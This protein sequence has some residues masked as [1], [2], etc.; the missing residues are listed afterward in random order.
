[1]P[2]VSDIRKRSVLR[3][4][5]ILLTAVVVVGLAYDAY[6][7]ADLAPTYDA[8]KSSTLSQGDLFRAEAA[9][10]ALAALAILVRPRRYSALFA[11]MV[12]AGGLA[13]VLAYRYID[14]GAIGPLPSMYEPIW[15]AEK[16]RSAFA[17]G[18][19][20]LAAAALLAVLHV[21][22]RG[23]RAAVHRVGQQR[24]WPRRPHADAMAEQE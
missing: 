1:M 19:A 22:R 18:A 11:F 5:R 17:E 2:T 15:Y 9:G 3:G 23:G 10:A 20:A 16:T 12:A 13:A 8:I 4:L 21:E 7:H 6:V 14:I 24:L